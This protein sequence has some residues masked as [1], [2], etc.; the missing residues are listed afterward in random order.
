MESSSS[1]S[2]ATVDPDKLSGANPG[3]ALNLVN[4]NWIETEIF[5]KLPDPL[6]G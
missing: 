6:N 1:L 3:R 2:W 5:E 4:G